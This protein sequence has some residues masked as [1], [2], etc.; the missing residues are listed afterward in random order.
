MLTIGRMPEKVKPFFRPLRHL[1]DHVYQY[2]W[3]LTLALCVG[4]TGTVSAELIIV[5]PFL[6]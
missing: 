3:G 5:L 6:A 2:Y 4:Q 1:G